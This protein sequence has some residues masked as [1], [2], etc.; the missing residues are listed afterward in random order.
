MNRFMH[1]TRPY[2]L[3][4]RKSPFAWNACAMTAATWSRSPPSSTSGSSVLGSHR[5]LATHAAIPSSSSSL[6]ALSPLSV[7][8]LTAPDPSYATH[9][10][11][12]RQVAAHL[13]EHGILKISLRFPDTSSAF[14]H[15]LLLGLHA[16]EGHQLPISHSA[17]RGWFWDVRPV[18]PASFSS[19]TSAPSSS[20]SDFSSESLPTA[21][22]SGSAHQARSETMGEFPWH[23][24]CSYENP[25]PRYF[26]LQVLQHDRRG[27]GT[28]SVMDV[29]RL[30]ST[31]EHLSPAARA[32]LATPQFRMA[33]PPEFIK[34]PCRDSIVGSL[35]AI[36]PTAAA[37]AETSRLLGGPGGSLP[38]PSSPPS[39]D[40]ESSPA[41][42]SVASKWMRTSMR[43][44]GDII[45]PLTDEAA[46]ALDELDAALCR[47]GGQSRYTMHL[48]SHDM[49]TGTI[50][51]V[52]NRRW[53]HARNEVRDAQRHL[54][55]V[56]WDAV[57]F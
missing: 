30:V 49:P 12:L 35:L 26:A 19:S 18:D 25:P 16:H 48:S 14:L 39:A 13:E 56:R 42:H 2:L 6:S 28:L 37:T 41:S 44:R 40:A 54:R 9:R 23:T 3:G 20:S 32:V 31:G 17:G 45:T 10:S 55:R 43:F 36:E 21:Y 47:A 22:Q 5:R 50:L 34:D 33:I 8:Q 7:P 51:L 11:H 4:Q 29:R 1:Q 46:Q 27:G 15:Q 57:A 24:D 38:S 53:L 52:D